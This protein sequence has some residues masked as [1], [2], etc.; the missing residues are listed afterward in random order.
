MFCPPLASSLLLSNEG[1]FCY[2]FSFTFGHDLQ[3]TRKIQAGEG[4]KKTQKRLTL[5]SLKLFEAFAPFDTFRWRQV[6]KWW[7]VMHWATAAFFW[8]LNLGVLWCNCDVFFRGKSGSKWSLNAVWVSHNSLEW[9]SFGGSL[10]GLKVW[11]RGDTVLIFFVQTV[12]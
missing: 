5:F 6:Q 11:P 7:S 8:K 10:A 12:Q 2:Q 1:C 9:A 4:K 3:V